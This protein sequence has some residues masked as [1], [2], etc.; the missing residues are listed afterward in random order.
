MVNVP[1]LAIQNLSVARGD[2]TILAG[3]DLAIGAG[4]TWA[5]L[6]P[7]GAGKS[8][9]LKTIAG[10]LPFSGTI[11]AM[12]TDTRTLSPRQRAKTFAYVPQHSALD[13]PLTAREVV[14]QGR[15]AHQGWLEQATKRDR[16]AVEE[17]LELAKATPL[18]DRAFSRLSYGERRL[19]LLARALAT[20]AP[21]L[22][23]DEPTAA[24]DVRNSLEILEVLATLGNVGR[25]V[26]VALHQL[27]E[28]RHIASHALLLRQGHAAHIGRVAEVIAPG[29]VADVYAVA[30]LENAGFGYRKLGKQP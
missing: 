21:I 15:F 25:S 14:A 23:L 9:L 7:N 11:Q 18:A 3:I 28:A 17:A 13:A 5:L 19:V 1:V 26:L 22:L 27:D 29:P 12:D 8:T 4:E 2:R 24:L 16:L 30:L 10:L 20:H 6:G